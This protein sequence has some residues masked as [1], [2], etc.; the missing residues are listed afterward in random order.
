M[1]DP[2]LL[3]VSLSDLCF[4]SQPPP[5]LALQS[6]LVKMLINWLV[7]MLIN[8]LVKMLINWLVK[9]LIDPLVK[10]LINWLVIDFR[11]GREGAEINMVQTTD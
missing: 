3:A 1:F 10:M 11:E 2:L 7:E 6:L 9:M 5:P 8:W 4:T